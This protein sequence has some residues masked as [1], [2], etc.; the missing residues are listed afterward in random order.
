MRVFQPWRRGLYALFGAAPAAAV[1]VAMS[2]PAQTF[3]GL[4][5]SF[6]LASG[7]DWL[8]IAFLLAAQLGTAGLVVATL[9]EIPIASAWL[10]WST[11]ACIA[12]GAGALLPY[13]PLFSAA[14]IEKAMVSDFHAS[15]VGY[16]ML[17][18]WMFTGP[19]VVGIHYLVR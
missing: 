12:L 11:V 8:L 2:I 4:K 6:Y 10:S 13:G 3:L 18:L 5:G 7:R 1:L 16:A 15:E 14:A 9:V 17:A 19:I